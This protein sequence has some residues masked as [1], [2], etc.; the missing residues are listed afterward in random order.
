MSDATQDRINQMYSSSS[1]PMY[2]QNLT[3]KY[4]SELSQQLPMYMTDQT[5]A[6]YK[7]GYTVSP[8]HHDP[9]KSKHKQRD[10]ILWVLLTDWFVCFKN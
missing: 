5:L 4:V 2:V 7:R 1:V 3:L 9:H 8:L 6:M 10:E